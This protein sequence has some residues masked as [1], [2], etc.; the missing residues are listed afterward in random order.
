M[1]EMQR[2]IGLRWLAWQRFARVR[3][4]KDIEEEQQKLMAMQQQTVQMAAT[5]LAGGGERC[6]LTAT[7]IDV[8]VLIDVVRLHA[9]VGPLLR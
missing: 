9:D 4:E 5:H 7:G 1:P 8:D 2:S 6:H 3:L